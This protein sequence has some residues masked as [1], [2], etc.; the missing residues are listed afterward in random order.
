MADTNLPPSHERSTIVRSQLTVQRLLPGVVEKVIAEIIVLALPATL[1][2]AA[3]NY[4]SPLA[5]SAF[6][7]MLAVA[8][9]TFTFFLWRAR[10]IPAPARTTDPAPP[11]KGA[12]KISYPGGQDV[13][14]MYAGI[15]VGR[16]QIS[17]GIL[18][19][20]GRMPITIPVVGASVFDEHK[21]AQKTDG[22]RIYRDLAIMVRQMDTDRIN[23]LGVGLPGEVDPVAGTVVGTPE[24]W[25]D[26]EHFRR[27]LAIALSLHKECVER[28][29]ISAE[30]SP[31]EQVSALERMIRIDNDVNCAA[32]AI[33]N[34]RYFDEVDWSNFACV[35]LGRTGVG[36]GLVLN[37]QMYYGSDGAAGEI[38]HIAVDVLPD[39][40]R[41]RCECGRDLDSLHLQALA[42]GDGLLQLADKV[43]PAK[44]RELVDATKADDTGDEIVALETLLRRDS[45]HGAGAVH[46][47][48]GDDTMRQFVY[49]ALNEHNR[50]LSIGLATLLNLLDLDHIVLGGGIVE[51]LWDAEISTERG[52]RAYCDELI[53]QVGVRV[54]HVAQ[55]DVHEKIVALDRVSRKTYAWQGAALTFCDPSHRSPW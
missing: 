10:P 35:Y 1:F 25:R 3:K 52:T 28:F 53:R 42:S 37:H 55:Q 4:E 6:L 17:R 47:L 39:S 16:H 9:L 13:H 51:A 20:T 21:W 48:A 26:F 41:P 36:G 2:F 34:A 14:R 30:M 44:Y 40:F 22:S 11:V 18:A 19:V 15:D 31:H 7:L 33:F 29:G 23:G 8:A 49:S 12:V 38:G 32:R 54:L 50:Y 5:W 46:D 45:R 24:G 27:E 43:D